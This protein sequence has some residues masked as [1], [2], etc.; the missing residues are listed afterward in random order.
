[1]KTI[2][3]YLP[4]F[5]RIKENDEWWGEGF[6]E[7]TNVKASQPLFEG[8]RQPRTPKDN[9]YYDLTD[10][11]SIRWQ[12]E[13]AAKYGINGF[14][15]YHYW[16]A[17]KM[18]LE[19]PVK[20]LRSHPDI[21]LEYCFSWANE[22]WTRAWDGKNSKVLL[23]QHY[24]GEEEW[25]EHYRYLSEYFS[26]PR[27]IK[28]DGKPVLLIYRTENIPRCDEMIDFWNTLAKQDGYEGLFLLETL[29]SF[30]NKACLENS[31]GVVQFE[32]MYSV[33]NNVKFMPNLK[34]LF[35]RLFRLVERLKYE[36]V[37]EGVLSVPSSIREKDVVPGVFVGWDNTPRKNRKGLVITG[38]TPEKFE[39]YCL[40]KLKG[41]KSDYVFI[42]AWNEWAEGAYL[43]PDEHYGEGYLKAYSN[44]LRHI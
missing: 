26:D 25:K 18:V 14:C 3:F 34:R 32:P 1:M 12:S 13:L 8:H 15:F 41:N 40:E 43:E 42:N 10:V 29:N 39:K 35:M 16:F 20:V 11:E 44:V 38:G 19:K 5:H 36:D 31:G 23:A 4:Q 9:R 22:P 24:G 7:W 28:K 21:D 30:Q 37:W 33:K 27:Y 17:G 2:A 6:T